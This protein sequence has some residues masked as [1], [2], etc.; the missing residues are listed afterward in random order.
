MSFGIPSNAW[1]VSSR[2]SVIEALDLPS[3]LGGPRASPTSGAFAHLPTLEDLERRYLLHVL[4]AAG[5]NRTR[6]AEVLGIDRR[7]CTG[8]R[9]GSASS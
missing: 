2:G 6:A 9:G 8:W 3:G 5:G 4:D 7:T 1:S